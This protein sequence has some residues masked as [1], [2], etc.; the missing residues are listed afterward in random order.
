MTANYIQQLDFDHIANGSLRNE[1][2]DLNALTVSKENWA[3]GEQVKTNLRHMSV[4]LQSYMTEI[5]SCFN[6]SI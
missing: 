5:K 2:C 1:A 3:Q 6:F 4:H